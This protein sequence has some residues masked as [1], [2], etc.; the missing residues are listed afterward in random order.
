MRA[1]RRLAGI[2]GYSRFRL[3]FLAAAIL[4]L[5]L[6]ATALDF[7]TAGDP[8]SP[9]SLSALLLLLLL[10]ALAPPLAVSGVGLQ[11]GFAL[12]SAHSW[13]SKTMI[14]R[15]MHFYRA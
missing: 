9:P 1:L 13:C 11:V 14:Q 4:A 2:A 7:L 8:V 15:T 12:V 10:T 3:R 6:S 5:A